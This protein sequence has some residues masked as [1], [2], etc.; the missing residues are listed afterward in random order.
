MAKGK[1]SPNNI[2]AQYNELDEQARALDKNIQKTEKLNYLSAQQTENLSKQKREYD[3]ISKKLDTLAKQMS[4]YDRAIVDSVTNFDAMDESLLSINN[5]MKGNA[6]LSKIVEMRNE[7]IKGTLNSIASILDGNEELSN[8]QKESVVATAQ[9]YSGMGA[10][11]SNLQRKIKQGKVGQDAYNKSV[12]ASYENF[13]ELLSK[14]DKSTASGAL[15][16]EKLGLAKDEMESFYKGAQRSDKAMGALSAGM[17]QL[18]VPILK[19]GSDVIMDLVKNAG[20]NLPVLMSLLAVAAAK[21]AYDLGKIG[22]KFEIINKYA[23]KEADIQGDIEIQ[24]AKV[25]RNAEAI[26]D[27]S[28]KYGKGTLIAA[29]A[30][31]DFQFSLKSAAVSFKESAATGFFGRALG[32][33][34]Y[35]AAQM[36]LAGISA[37]Q[38]ASNTT[39][40][41]KSAGIL[42][43]SG[44]ILAADATIFAQQ[45][46]AS[47]DD[48]MSI[49]GAFKLSDKLS[50]ETA[51]NLLDGAV[52]VGKISG[53]TPEQVIGDM[54]SASKDMLS[55]QIRS[56]SELFKQ[57]GFA[58]SIGVDFTQIAQLG[59]NMVLNYKDSIRA[60]MKLSAMLGRNVDLSQ[61]RSLFASGQT[62]EAM[63]ELRTKGLDFGKMNMFQQQQMLQTLPGATEEMLRRLNDPTF[64]QNGGKQGA[65]KAGNVKATNVGYLGRVQTAA[66][67]AATANAFIS[68]DKAILDAEFGKQ[69]GLAIAADPTLRKLLQAQSVLDIQK[70]FDLAMDQAK[71]L[72]PAAAAGYGA[73]MGLNMLKDAA[74]A[75]A[76]TKV[77]GAAPAGGNPYGFVDKNGKPL[78]MAQANMRLTKGGT[79][80]L[81][82]PPTTGIKG[83][84]L[85]LGKMLPKVAGVAGAGLDAYSRYS[86]GQTATQTAVG[87]GSAAAGGWAGAELGAGLGLMT[88]PAAP[89]M[90]PILSLGGGIIGYYGGG[91]LADKLTGAGQP[92][93][94]ATPAT[95]LQA[96][97]VDSS[98]MTAEKIVQQNGT[99][100][101]ILTRTHNTMNASGATLEQMKL[102]KSNSDS[103]IEL[104]NAVK[105][106]TE[107][108][109]AFWADN[110]EFMKQN[111]AVYID[112]NKITSTLKRIQKRQ[113][114]SVAGSKTI[115]K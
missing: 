49:V 41:A 33:V 3:S 89:F 25:R 31:A 54:A 64:M 58:N 44:K 1:T 98:A 11:I 32:S 53:Y 67:A 86:S 83:N 107:A 27:L 93:K 36:Q 57:V 50:A 87:V 82:Q 22:N 91:K 55:Y 66:G 78:T 75:K 42:G 102:L 97:G 84:A 80:P 8:K 4:D 14:I 79:I 46:N 56:S 92:V 104:G 7:N 5:S 30:A 94:S 38:I 59:K 40:A 21:F 61:V 16:H 69:F 60:E 99:L 48:I 88:G 73:G 72:I 12:I 10:S 65:L 113:G 19:E 70:S 74:F 13:D 90:V 114:I 29:Q 71:Y 51:L 100:E 85:K 26:G 68:A 112:G 18:N 15:L 111:P 110:G 20:G 34:G 81:S 45:Y 39:I 35:G 52:Q 109:L 103:L 62:D 115:I 105:D 108:Q 24:T 6:K 106:L 28:K 101:K 96:K 37:S 47:T 63:K 23:I 76:G 2:Q 43:Q 95:P 17:S 77:P 9:S